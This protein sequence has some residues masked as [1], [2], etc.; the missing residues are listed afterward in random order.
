MCYIEKSHDLTYVVIVPHLLRS[1]AIYLTCPQLQKQ[2]EKTKKM[3]I[4]FH[5]FTLLEAN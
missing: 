1:R 4:L 3:K 2:S 5:Y